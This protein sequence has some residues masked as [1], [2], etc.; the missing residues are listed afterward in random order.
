MAAEGRGSKVKA[1]EGDT[2]ITT[3]MSTKNAVV[4][5]MTDNMIPL[6]EWTVQAAMVVVTVNTVVRKEEGMMDHKTEGTAVHKAEDTVVRKVGETMG[7]KVGDMAARKVVVM[8]MV[9]LKGNMDSPVT[10]AKAWVIKVTIDGLKERTRKNAAMENLMGKAPEHPTAVGTAAQVTSLMLLI[11][12][13]SKLE[14]AATLPCSK[15]PLA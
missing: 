15:T 2:T 4:E 10:V 1:K 6:G 14:T 13:A 7:H 5:R 3:K 12:P 9:G 8:D 11:T